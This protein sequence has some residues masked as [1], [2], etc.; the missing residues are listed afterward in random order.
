[1]RGELPEEVPRMESEKVFMIGRYYHELL[2]YIIVE[3]LGFA[4]WGDVEKEHDM[5]F[6]TP[7]GTRYR[8]RGFLDVA[9]CEIPGQPGPV[10]V[11][12]KTMTSRVYGMGQPPADLM[13][14]YEAQVKLYLEF[15]DLPTGIIVVAEKDNPHRFREIVVERDGALVDRIMEGWD[16][17]A[18]CLAEGD[19]VP[20]C[21]CHNPA[22]CPARAVYP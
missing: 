8:V 9:R 17:V 13:E 10:L 4:T 14:K 1:M 20:D 16:F 5:N 11:D 6:V 3:A 7:G 18:D 22:T 21:T 12:V 15:E 19:T 2:Q